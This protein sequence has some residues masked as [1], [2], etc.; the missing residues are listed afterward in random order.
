MTDKIEKLTEEKSQIETRYEKA[1]KTLKEIDSLAILNR[2]DT[3][4][5]LKED[6]LGELKASF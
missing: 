2:K 3:P 4:D 6:N 5:L 1:K